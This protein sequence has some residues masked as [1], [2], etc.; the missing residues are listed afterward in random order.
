L[1]NY[2]DALDSRI[3]DA[4][5]SSIG[6]YLRDRANDPIVQPDGADAF[7]AAG[8][9]MLFTK[10]PLV[11]VPDSTYLLNNVKAAC[12][13]NART[14]LVTAANLGAI[15]L[16]CARHVIEEVYKHSVEFAEKAEVAQGEY[17]T[18]FESEYIPHLRL[19]D[20]TEALERLLTAAELARVSDLRSRGS[21][22]VPSVV[23]S[24]V[25]NGHYL[26]RDKPAFKTAYGRDQTETEFNEQT[27]L[28]KS[29]GDADARGQAMFYLA[30]FP[31]L[32][33]GTFG[34]TLSKVPSGYRWMLWA[35]GAIGVS[36]LAYFAFR[37]REALRSAGSGTLQMFLAL[38]APVLDNMER[39]RDSGPGE[40]TWDTIAY[41][42]DARSTATRATLH[43]LSRAQSGTMSARELSKELPELHVGQG[44]AIVRDLLRKR[45][46]FM[47]TR[48]GRFQVG[49]PVPAAIILAARALAVPNG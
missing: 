25:L 26:T 40:A 35:S 7:P 8:Q 41:E 34:S 20:E 14:I 33:L 48:P 46:W 30:L 36:A 21:K 38:Y 19:I 43:A 3:V 47:E 39:M 17:V 10:E 29:A 1:A 15:R 11:V 28:L 24:L 44:D 32:L 42:V 49:K 6:K 9:S 2:S 22:D 31:A 5:A 13:R 12:E 37:H 23:L 45:P 4:L 18:R 16:Y 27:E